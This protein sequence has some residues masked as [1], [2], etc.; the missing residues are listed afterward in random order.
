MAESEPMNNTTWILVSD[1]SR[2]RLFATT[3]KLKPWTLVQ[4]LDH[5]KSRLKGQDITT[6]KAGRM[7]QSFGAGSRPAMASPT[8]TKEVEAEHFTQELAALLESGHGRNEF[9]RLVLVAP[10]HF[11]GLLRKLLSPPLIK[12]IAATI[13]KDLTQLHE[14]DLPERLADVL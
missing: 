2:A 9:S 5:P 1:A 12:R 13:D 10:P 14:R 7:R 3:G 4:E 8:S 6:D 11:L